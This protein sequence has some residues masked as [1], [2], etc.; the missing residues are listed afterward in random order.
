MLTPRISTLD[1]KSLQVR[2]KGVTVGWTGNG[3]CATSHGATAHCID[4][5]VFIQFF[6]ILYFRPWVR[7]APRLQERFRSSMHLIQPKTHL[8]VIDLCAWLARGA[9]LLVHKKLPDCV[10]R[11][12]TI[13][14]QTILYLGPL[15]ELCLCKLSR[16]VQR[17]NFAKTIAGWPQMPPKTQ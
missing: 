2:K 11:E 17:W 14:A 9:S 12:R 4:S 1:L 5:I 3:G 7:F 8:F 16:A 13:G 15:Y 6:G 10:K